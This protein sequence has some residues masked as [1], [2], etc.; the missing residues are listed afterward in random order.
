MIT[1]HSKYM[2]TEM[3]GSSENIRCLDDPMWQHKDYLVH[4]IQ[5]LRNQ[6]KAF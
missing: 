2:S 1:G 5:F 4:K 3:L 6:M